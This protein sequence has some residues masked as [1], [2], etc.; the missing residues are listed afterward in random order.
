MFLYIAYKMRNVNFVLSPLCCELYWCAKPVG[1]AKI[2][3]VFTF[4]PPFHQF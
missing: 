3:L 1:M 4:E 2:V